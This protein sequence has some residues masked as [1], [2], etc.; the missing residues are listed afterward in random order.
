METGFTL[1]PRR[2]HDDGGSSSLEMLGCYSDEPGSQSY[3]MPLRFFYPD[4]GNFIAFVANLRSRKPL[5]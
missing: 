3:P 1:F 5:H 2:Q 4:R